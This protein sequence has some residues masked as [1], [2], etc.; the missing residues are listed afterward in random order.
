MPRGEEHREVEY[1][2]E[3]YAW[4]DKGEHGDSCPPAY[5]EK[6]LHLTTIIFWGD[7]LSTT[8]AGC[9]KHAQLLPWPLLKS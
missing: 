5:H 9:N 1:G 7:Y 2:R 4:F 6:I 8:H 3:P